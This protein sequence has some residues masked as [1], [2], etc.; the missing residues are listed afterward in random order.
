VAVRYLFNE[1]EAV[2]IPPGPLVFA[3]RGLG[4]AFAARPSA[5]GALLHQGL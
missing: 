2:D 5:L 1:P 4:A 3:R